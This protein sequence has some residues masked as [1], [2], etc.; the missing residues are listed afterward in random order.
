MT[1]GT[2]NRGWVIPG[3]WPWAVFTGVL[4]LTI[5][6][7]AWHLWTRVPPIEERV[8]APQSGTVPPDRIQ[9][10]SDLVVENAKLAARIAEMREQLAAAPC[11]PGT[12]R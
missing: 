12:R 2:T 8:G 4:V 7:L 6:V 9:Q 3:K 5:A 11:P 1:E 10:A